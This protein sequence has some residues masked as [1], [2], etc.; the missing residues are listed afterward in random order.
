[1]IKKTQKILSVILTLSTV[2]TIGS[3]TVQAAERVQPMGMYIKE[4]VA[5]EP[6]YISVDWTYKSLGVVSGDNRQGSS[7]LSIT[8][9]YEDSGTT[10]AS[11]AL[12]GSASAEAGVVFAKMEAKAGFEVTFS[13]SWTKGSS[14]G[15]SYSIAPGKFE[16]V[17]V[18]IPAV[19]TSGRL[20]YK[21]YMD[22]NPKDVF[23]EYKTLVESYAPKK[24]SVHYKVSRVSTST[25]NVPKGITV[26]TPA[27]M[28]KAQ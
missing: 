13:R 26:Y 27:G 1:M 12:Y 17:G 5:Y 22:S 3:T 28:Y 19:K 2:I 8:Y 23:Y 15:A 11:L 24:H 9:D 20:K 21:V 4:L 16:M 10:T 7:P 25:L 18:Y 14:A 6:D